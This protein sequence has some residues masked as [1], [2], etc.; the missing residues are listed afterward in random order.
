M[1]QRLLRHNFCPWIHEQTFIRWLHFIADVV[2]W[3]E[4][5]KSNISMR[6]VNITSILQGC[7]QKN[8]FFKGW[9]WFKFNNLELA[10]GKN[11]WRKGLKIKVRKFWRQIPMFVAVKVEN[12]VKGMKLKDWFNS[13]T[14]FCLPRLITLGVSYSMKLLLIHCYWW[15]LY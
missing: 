7:Y 3:P 8:N 11:L 9:S 5:D 15:I 10:L 13:K 12:R 14:I 6:E 2:I 4:I 1:K